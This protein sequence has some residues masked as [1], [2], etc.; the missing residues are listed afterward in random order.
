MVILK[1][2]FD[3]KESG[4]PFVDSALETREK[5]KDTWTAVTKYKALKKTLIL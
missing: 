5:L 4:V 1:K 3:Y 2:E